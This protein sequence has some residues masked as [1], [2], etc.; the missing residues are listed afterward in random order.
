MHGKRTSGRLDAFHVHA[1]NRGQAD[2]IAVDHRNNAD[3]SVA[4][5]LGSLADDVEHRLGVGRRATDDVEH[6]AGRRLLLQGLPQLVEQP[7][8]LD[9]DHGLG[10]EA[11]DQ[12]DLLVAERAHLL[13]VHAD[14]ADQLAFLEHRHDQ[15]GPATG[16]LDLGD[17]QGIAFDVCLLL[18]DVGN[19]DQLLGRGD[20]AEAGSWAGA[21]DRFAL[22][23]LGPCGRRAGRRDETES[24]A[25]AQ[26]QVAEPGTA[27]AHRILQH[28]LEHGLKLAGRRADDLQ[29][30]GG[31]RLLL[32]RLAEIV[33]ALAQLVEQPRVLDG[34]DGLAGES[35]Q[36]CDLFVGERPGHKPHDAEQ[37]DRLIA[38]HHGHDRDRA[39]AAGQEV[40]AADGK[41]RWGIR[42]VGNIHDPAIKQGCAV[43]VIPCEGGTGNCASPRFDASRIRCGDGRGIDRVPVPERDAD[44]G[45]RKELQPASHDGVEHRLRVAEGVAY[46]GEDFGGRRLLLQRLGQLLGAR[47]LGLEQARVLDG[48]HGLVGEGL[49]AAAICGR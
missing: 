16:E 9:G 47:L 24:V 28:G 6:V 34:D 38:A 35:L 46:D 8:V 15:E 1:V 13:A 20:T 18:C 7:D 21:D 45:A 14:R 31:R 4:Q 2:Q 27:D 37:A 44:K 11:R 33:G 22:P 39:V 3:I 23:P 19:V 25:F 29:H 49:G 32:Q 26:P 17:E 36:H 42:H 10:S 41:F 5:L 43:H 12:L 30:L 40:L 48:D